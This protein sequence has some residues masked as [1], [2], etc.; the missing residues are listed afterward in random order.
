MSS[1]VLTVSSQ[2]IIILYYVVDWHNKGLD[3][4]ADTPC[5]ILHTVLLGIDKYVWYET[6]HKW[7]KNED[8]IFAARL[9]TSSLDGLSITSVRA[10][11][12]LQYKNSL[13]GRHFKALQ[14]LTIFHITPELFKEKGNHI[15]HHKYE[16]LMAI[17]R[18]TGELGALLWF[19]E[20]QNMEE[21]LVSST[22]NRWV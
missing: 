2:T 20:I 11:Y 13:V 7:K 3:P 15:N 17:W 5:E 19:P 1:S 21:Y 6:S 8:G 4:H 10:Q 14:Q 16:K 22:K 12:M 9:Q 18:A